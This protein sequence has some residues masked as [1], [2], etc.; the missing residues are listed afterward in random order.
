MKQEYAKLEQ[1]LR[2]SEAIQTQLKDE[3]DK[4]HQ[5]LLQQQTHLEEK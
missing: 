2:G 5:V 3:K 1:Q 4:M